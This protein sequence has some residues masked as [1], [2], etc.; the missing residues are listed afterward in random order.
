[1]N[2]HEPI[3][4]SF[5]VPPT[6]LRDPFVQCGAGYGHRFDQGS[7]LEGRVGDHQSWEGVYPLRNPFFRVG[8]VSS[9]KVS[10]IGE[11]ANP[12]PPFSIRAFNPTQLYN[13][14]ASIAN[15]PDGVWLGCETSHTIAA[16]CESTR[17]FR[18]YDVRTVFSPDVP[19]HTQNA[20][21]FRGKAAGTVAL[22][23]CP[24]KTFPVPLPEDIQ[25]TC[26]MVDA[27]VQLGQGVELYVSAIYGPPVCNQVYANGEAIFQALLQCTWER[28][29]RFGGLAVITGDFNRCLGEVG[30][31]SRMQMQ[32]WVDS[33]ELA[34]ALHGTP[35]QPT[36]RDST[37]KT[38]VLLNRAML[39]SFLA[40]ATTDHWL[41]DSHPVLETIVDVDVL[42][43]PKR[44][45]SLPRST[46]DIVFDSQCLEHVGTEVC[47]TREEMFTAAIHGRAPD[48][49]FRQF[50]LAFDEIFSRSAVTVDGYSTEVPIACRGKGLR[51]ISKIV[52]PTI[53][54]VSPSRTDEFAPDAVGLGVQLRRQ[55]RQVRRIQSLRRQVA[56]LSRSYTPAGRDQCARLWH[57]ILHADVFGQ[58]FV[59]W[60]P[61]VFHSWLPLQLPTEE[62]LDCLATDVQ[63]F[64]TDELNEFRH[65]QNLHVR[66]LT[67]TDVGKGGRAA[68]RKTK[69]MSAPPLLQIGFTVGHELPPQRWFPGVT[70][71][72]F[73]MN[74][75]S[76]L[77]A[78]MYAS[79]VRS[80]F[81][82]RSRDLN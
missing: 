8:P 17:R 43:E 47:A 81:C 12:G 6:L 33:A 25:S 20:G 39:P 37:R 52:P 42:L 48:E 10:P 38:F 44:I 50:S 21:V 19:R 7:F 66:E 3:H 15:W 34:F 13:N 49:A 60:F 32:G 75:A 73:C 69:E 9:Q 64:V 22:S 53:P 14:E 5:G 24:M 68:Y 56:A 41:F 78:I 40:C 80:Q 82:F 16:R 67:R 61:A 57:T 2:N 28:A 70:Q 77:L 79:R 58:A 62:Y 76:L 55:V 26:R 72:C 4:A 30:A 59:Q 31:W 23:R 27:I 63:L 74:R 54:M 46:D 1:M 36:C 65:Q 29:T 71:F 45:W 51:P 18:K 35:M 11:A